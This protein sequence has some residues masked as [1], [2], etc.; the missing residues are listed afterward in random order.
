MGS[1]SAA[2][3]VAKQQGAQQQV[4]TLAHRHDGPGIL[5]LLRIAALLQNLLC[6]DATSDYDAWPA[7]PSHAPKRTY[8]LHGASERSIDAAAP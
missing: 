7:E 2:H 8:H 6:T 1:R 3:R 4:A 5:P